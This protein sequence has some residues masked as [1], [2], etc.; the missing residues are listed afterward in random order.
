MLAPP[1]VS[2]LEF[3][4]EVQLDVEVKDEPGAAA[5]RDVDPESMM[6]GAGLE[7]E[8]SYAMPP[9]EEGTDEDEEEDG[10]FVG[11]VSVSISPVSPVK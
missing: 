4:Q 9:I 11:D 2:P 8:H 6:P 5:A 10:A 3:V 7:G 1:P